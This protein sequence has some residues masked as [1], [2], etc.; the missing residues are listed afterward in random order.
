MASRHLRYRPVHDD[1]MRSLGSSN[2]SQFEDHQVGYQSSCLEQSVLRDLVHEDIKSEQ[3]QEYYSALA[4]YAASFTQQDTND[5]VPS[6]RE[7]NRDEAS[8]GHQSDFRKELPLIYSQSKRS[9][10]ATPQERYAAPGGDPYNLLDYTYRNVRTSL[11]KPIVDEKVRQGERNMQRYLD[12]QT[13]KSSVHS[14]GPRSRYGDQEPFTYDESIY[15]PDW[16]DDKYCSKTSIE[17]TGGSFE[18]SQNRK[19]SPNIVI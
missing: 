9:V 1:E 18:Y 11:D 15:C 17:H 5:R 14:K 16:R 10:Q 12:V 3:C 13:I 19:Y 6:W 8:Q 7:A 2:P 4:Q